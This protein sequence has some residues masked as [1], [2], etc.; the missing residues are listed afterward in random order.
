MKYA[1]LELSTRIIG[2]VVFAFLVLVFLWSIRGIIL[3]LLL[4]L[5]LA[6][7][8]EPLVDYLHHKKIP[9]ALSVSMVY[10]VVI[11][12]AVLV[13]YLMVPPVLDQFKILK[14]NLPQ[15]SQALQTQFGGLNVQG[16]LQNLVSGLSS[17]GNVLQRTF[18]A[19]NGALDVI[20]VLV[21]SFYLVA[22]QKG[23][24]TFVASLIPSRHHEFTLNLITKIQQ[25]MGMWVLGQVIISLGIF[26]FT[27][28]GL[29]ILH[30][31]YALALSLVAG[32]F[33][34]VPYIGP[35]LSAIPAMFVGFIQHPTLAIW[36]AILYLL[37]HEVEGYVLVPKI[38][39][40][41]VGVSPLLT[42]IALL[43]G[44]QLAGIVGLLISVPLATALTV[45]V[46]EFWPSNQG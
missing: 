5:I 19:F 40:K 26:I 14:D 11:G 15:Y 43:V 4:A 17:G 24:K 3:L 9:R 29:S 45:V 39:E 33:E 44:Y 31:Q 42:L 8:M 6:S 12:S 16:F 18:G 35:F 25:K 36:V 1:D 13:V 37:V 23:M 34:I 7:A 46:N 20:S 28:V 2:K 32:L 27:Y 21:I 22:E 30:V 41:A 38:M 10:L